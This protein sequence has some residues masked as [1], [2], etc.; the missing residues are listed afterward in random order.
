MRRDP[1]RH[2]VERWRLLSLLEGRRLSTHLDCYRLSD[3]RLPQR[4]VRQLH[5]HALRAGHPAVL[6]PLIRSRG[7]ALA[8]VALALGLGLALSACRRTPDQH[9]QRASEAIYEK[10]PQLA[11]REYRLALD[12]IERDTSVAGQQVRAKALRGA[13]DI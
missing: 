3:R 2:P 10:N 7:S 9:L 5:R 6:S 4:R 11:L 8:A 13:A 1:D 12:E